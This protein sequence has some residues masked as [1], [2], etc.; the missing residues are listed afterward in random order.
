LT[1]TANYTYGKSL[2]N[3]SDA[4]PDK[5]VLTSGTTQGGDVTFGAPLSADRSLSAFD[6]KHAFNAVYIFDLPFGHGRKL[7]S[8]AHGPLN[9]LVGGW[10]TAGVFR[11]QSSY[12]F[13][14]TIS[15]TNGLSADITHTIRPDLVPG[16]PLKN[17]LYNPNCQAS[18]LC[19]PYINPAAFMRPVKGQLGDAGRILDIR[20]PMQQFFDASVQKDFALPFGWS[21][22]GKR[23]LQFRVDALNALNHPNFQVGSGNASGGPDFMGLPTEA[24]SL[25]VNPNGTFASVTN[26]SNTEYDAWA[27]FNNQ[28]L[29]TT[30][31]GAA[32]LAQIESMINAQ[33]LPS[34]LLP[35]D[36]Y[37]IQLPQ[38]FATTNPNAY[39]ITTLTGYK[40]YRLRQA[41]N[42]GF[43]QLRELAQPRYI[44][45]GVKLYF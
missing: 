39:D 18:T 6:I 40:E 29:H 30:T 11:L 15:D 8:G 41:Y 45:F 14:P 44:Q 2:D 32:I 17:P 22:D 33:R 27:T 12:P 19:Q 24:N 3:A 35:L 5:N 4:G 9:N 26:L 43:G 37:H 1:F 20:G 38:G 23:R 36:F 10:T 13:L 16:V 28:P 25:Q 31:A 34:H 42:P 21:R 7:L